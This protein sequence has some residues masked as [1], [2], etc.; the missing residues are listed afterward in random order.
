MGK[1]DKKSKR[2]IYISLI[3]QIFKTFKSLINLTWVTYIYGN[4]FKL[5]LGKA[6]GQTNYWI[7]LSE[8]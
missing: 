3:Q 1:K 8:N 7:L 4:L 2:E 6:H 5:L